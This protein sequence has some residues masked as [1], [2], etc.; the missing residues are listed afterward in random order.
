MEVE[1]KGA[2]IQ[3]VRPTIVEKV[4]LFGE[5]Q[6]GKKS[7]DHR[8]E[9]EIFGGY[10][11]QN[12]VESINLW[13]AR[14]DNQNVALQGLSVRYKKANESGYFYSSESVNEKIKDADQNNDTIYLDDAEYIKEIKV[15][16]ASA[17]GKIGALEFLTSFKDTRSFHSYGVGVS[18]FQDNANNQP[19]PPGETVSYKFKKGDV[20][21]YVVGFYGQFDDSHITQLGVYTAPATEINYYIRRPLILTYKKIQQDKELAKKIAGRLNLQKDGDKYKDAHLEREQ[22]NSSKVLL[23]FLEASSNHPELFRAVLEYL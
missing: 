3:K 18:K 5:P 22:S 4:N 13:Y 7:F 10:L 1:K 21:Q 15:T 11:P 16:T 14:T 23:Y 20:P 6:P 12:R 17:N 8:Q 9:I 2:L 19:A